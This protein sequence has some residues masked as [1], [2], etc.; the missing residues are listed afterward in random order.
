MS[1]WGELVSKIR[2]FFATAAVS[3]RLS[4]L[5]FAKSKTRKTNKKVLIRRPCIKTTFFVH[6]IKPAFLSNIFLK[7][8]F[9]S[10]RW[11]TLLNFVNMEIFRSEYMQRK[12]LL[13]YLRRRSEG[14]LLKGYENY[15]REQRK[16]HKKKASRT[17]WGWTLEGWR[18]TAARLAGW[19]RVIRQFW[20]VFIFGYIEV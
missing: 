15:Y 12:H 7:T 16:Q 1:E 19:R 11:F 8:L 9:F 10:P 3:C 17:Q 2:G 18:N 6:K 4:I 5:N 13:S 20:K 14:L